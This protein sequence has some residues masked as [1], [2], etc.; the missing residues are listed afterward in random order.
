MKLFLRSLQAT[1]LEVTAIRDVTP[2]P[3]NGCRP[4]EHTVVCN[5]LLLLNFVRTI[6]H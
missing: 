1:G 6:A 5:G 3:H 2:I 4:Q